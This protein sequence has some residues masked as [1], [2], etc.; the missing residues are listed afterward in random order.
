MARTSSSTYKTASEVLEAY[1][2][3]MRYLATLFR[4][5][6]SATTTVER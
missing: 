3:L 5:G 6:R 4:T 1:T 2:C